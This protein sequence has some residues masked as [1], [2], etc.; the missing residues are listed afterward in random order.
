M[1]IESLSPLSD[2]AETSFTSYGTGLF[3]AAS[4]IIVLSSTYY[5]LS[6]RALA[7]TIFSLA[8]SLLSIVV[9]WLMFWGSMLNWERH[10]INDSIDLQA[11]GL[12]KS[13]ELYIES[14]IA[15]L[16]RM[17]GRWTFDKGTNE[18]SWRAQA[19]ADVRDMPIFQ[20]IEWVG[21]DFR[22]KLVEP[23]EGNEKAVNLDLGFEERRR[24]ALINARNFNRTSVSN[25]VDL[26]QGDL[27]FLIYVP[28]RYDNKFQGFILGVVKVN[29]VLP[30]LI[31]LQ[32]LDKNF[33]IHIKELGR[34]IWSLDNGLDEGNSTH[35][36]NLKIRNINWKAEIIPTVEYY[37]QL[38]SQYI[39]YLP[40]FGFST[41]LLL[42]LA[43]L[44]YIRYRNLYEESLQQQKNTAK[45]NTELKKAESRYQGIN[46]LTPI[47]VLMVDDKGCI[48]EVN[49]HATSIFKYTES[50]FIGLSVDKL[51]PSHARSKHPKLREKFSKHKEQK[52]MAQRSMDLFGIDKFGDKIPL[53]I[54][55]SPVQLDGD[56]YT[57]V[58]ISDVTERRST[59]TDLQ[60]KNQEMNHLIKKLSE[61]NEQLER[62]AFI[63]SHDLQEPVRM[64]QSF[65]Q[66]LGNQLK[67]SLDEQQEKYLRYIVDGADRAH[68][69]IRDILNYSRLEP[70][71]TNKQEVLL[72]E[73]CRQVNISLSEVIDEKMAKFTWPED[74]PVVRAVSTQLFQVILNIVNNGLKF[75]QSDTPRVAIRVNDKA[76][77]WEIVIQDNGIGIDPTYHEKL[78]QVFY[79]LN[80]RSEYDGTG[81][82]LAVCKRILSLHDATITIDSTLNEGSS[83]VISWPKNS[84]RKSDAITNTIAELS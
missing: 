2:F 6:N 24:K 3:I 81:I 16:E 17:A 8:P 60:S 42:L 57:V 18:K 27:G 39:S 22:V 84:L 41:T 67:N 30:L 64:V 83:F 48:Q 9:I 69:M 14:Q 10:R 32:G 23:L 77:H 56:S 76:K 62:F 20:A 34:D 29:R 4:I 78:F 36:A 79:R 70:E 65:S 1:T 54:G 28:I 45:L 25:T 46:F 58:T 63:C 15:A 13:F 31:D 73:I 11:L 51:V 47:A 40:A 72:S 33:N 37:Q 12:E 80:T 7:A 68:Q 75:N 38:R 5:Y 19:R 59:L 61:S 55:L 44:F 49:Q 66:I 35:Y 52:R 21:N 50:E 74:M 43:L 82:G 53:E 26:A 71:E